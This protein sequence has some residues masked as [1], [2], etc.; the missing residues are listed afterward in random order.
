MASTLRKTIARI[1]QRMVDL[2]PVHP[3]RITKQ[4]NICGTPGCRCKDPEEP[5]KHGPYHYLSYTF[6]GI[7]RTLFVHR[8]QISEVKQRTKRYVQL[9]KLFT[10]LIEANIKL[11]REED[12]VGKKKSG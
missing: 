9:K 8:K 3:G 5:R 12:V 6:R 10:E 1:K 2:G 7:G 11:A 4:Y